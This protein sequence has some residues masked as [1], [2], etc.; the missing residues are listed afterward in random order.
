VPQTADSTFRYSFYAGPILALIV[1][2]W[3]TRLWGTENQVRLHTE[4]LLRQIEERK[5]AGAG[6]FLAAN[7]RDDWGDDRQLMISRLRVGLRFFNTLTI[8]AKE[9][10]IQ[11]EESG[12]IW[13]ARL[14]ITGAGSDVPPQAV[15]EINRLTSPFEL[16]WQKQSWKP[17]DW[18]LDKVSNSE[19]QLPAEMY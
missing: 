4:H 2:V 11:V 19:L 7:Y 17:W 8:T 16:R 15:E 5:W 9:T 6:E 13:S 18:K 10:R 1:G 3:L 14:Q 12:A